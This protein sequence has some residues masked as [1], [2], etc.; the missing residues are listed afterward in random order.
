VLT[1]NHIDYIRDCIEGILIQNVD[2]PIEIIIGEDESSDGTRNICI[3]YAKKYSGKIRLFLHSRKNVIKINKKPTGRFN[4]LYSLSKARGKYIAYCEGDDYW[5]HPLKLQKQVDFLQ[6]NPDFVMSS[7]EV[8][9]VF[10]GVKEKKI[11]GD[12]IEVSS[13]ED[14][15]KNRLF[16]NLN[17]IV[18]R[19]S[20]ISEIPKWF[21]KL[22]STHES[23]LLLIM[24]KGLNYHNKHIMGVKRKN[25]G[26][27]TEDLTYKKSKL[28]I[29]K[30]KIYFYKKLNNYTGKKYRDI[31]NKIITQRRINLIRFYLNNKL[32]KIMKTSIIKKASSLLKNWIIK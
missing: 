17:T 2:F 4:F 29:K 21:L 27:V 1:Y 11:F 31:I 32:K 24:L 26:G 10:E 6:K 18:F 23:F 7:H 12:P 30:N 8:E 15:L 25:P 20:A 5:T 19:S 28:F 16:I 9:I 14:L 3:E 13:F 22:W